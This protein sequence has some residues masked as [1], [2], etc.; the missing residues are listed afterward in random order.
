MSGILGGAAAHS[1]ITAQATAATHLARVA[2]DHHKATLLQLTHADRGGTSGTGIGGYELL[3]G[4][5]DCKRRRSGQEEAEKTISCWVGCS[6]AYQIILRQ[7]VSTNLILTRESA[8]WA[9]GQAWR[10]RRAEETRGAGVGSRGG[11]GG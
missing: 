6:A 7:R 1:E 4:H 2:L 3:V 8:C 10:C 9:R 5:F 11:P